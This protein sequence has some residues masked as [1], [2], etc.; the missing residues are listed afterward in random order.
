M[1]KKEVPEVSIKNTKEQIL[2]AYTE[3]LSKLEKQ[4]P[5]NPQE[6]KEKED[7]E[8]LINRV[9]EHSSESL[10]NDLATLKLKTMKQID[11]LSEE[12]LNEFKILSDIRQA[13]D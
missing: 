11:G 12:L 2:A 7:R 6:K 1:K 9:T 8:H 3:V 13:I 10:L 4:Q 5:E